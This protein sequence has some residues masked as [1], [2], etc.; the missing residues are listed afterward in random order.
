[1]DDGKVP[2][3]K[4]DAKP[5]RSSA[6]QEG[7]GITGDQQ[8]LVSLMEE[9][10]G[11]ELELQ[12][13][14]NLEHLIQTTQNALQE[15][16]EEILKITIELQKTESELQRE[17]ARKKPDPSAGTPKTVFRRVGLD[18]AAPR[19]VIEAARKSYRKSLH[20]DL[21]PVERKAEATR[22]FQE[23]EAAFDEIWHLRRFQ[24]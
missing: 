20:P 2:P 23:A 8:A 21:Q 1:M 16:N 13:R 5:E 9:W 17:R 19:F 24:T 3:D 15:A 12:R 11:L 7:V 10:I 14:L 22:R 18:P 6:P 4:A